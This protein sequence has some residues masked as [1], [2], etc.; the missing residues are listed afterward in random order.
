MS[1]K[2]KHTGAQVDEAVSKVL[3]GEVGGATPDWNAMEGESSYIENKPFGC[4]IKNWKKL[5]DFEY[6]VINDNEF[7]NRYVFNIGSMDSILFVKYYN[8]VSKNS[9]GTDGKYITNITELDAS[10]SRVSYSFNVLYNGW[11]CNDNCIYI[12]NNDNY[13]ICIE[14]K[15][16]L[17][18]DDP[19]NYINILNAISNQI[20][21]WNYNYAEEDVEFDYYKD[22]HITKINDIFIPDTI[23]RKS[24]I[25][26]TPFQ[27]YKENG[28]ILF[29]NEKV[30]N[31]YQVALTEYVGFDGANIASYMDISP[32][33]W[34]LWSQQS[35]K[36]IT[37]QHFIATMRHDLHQMP[38]IEINGKYINCEHLDSNV[39]VNNGY[40][41]HYVIATDAF[42]TIGF[43]NWTGFLEINP[44]TKKFR[45]IE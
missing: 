29:T 31:E 26:K 21:I 30:Y 22:T 8:Y 35:E 14:I 13:E 44:N 4:N 39:I 24:Q 18:S 16:Y 17:L 10:N 32:N 15:S 33:V 7:E 23:A 36:P 27:I 34:Y 25:N 37:M 43:D 6:S 5:S 41:R 1:Y 42:N 3:N 20:E 11:V 2:S 38:H 12:Y 19:S 45:F 9:N 40:I 28:G